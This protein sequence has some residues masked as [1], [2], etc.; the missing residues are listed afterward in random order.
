MRNLIQNE[1]LKLYKK[2]STWIL[3]GI[4]VA[5]AVFSL[6]IQG[7]VQLFIASTSEES[8]ID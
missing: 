1:R 5:L 2:A 6:A 8:A 3:V 7:A 4:V